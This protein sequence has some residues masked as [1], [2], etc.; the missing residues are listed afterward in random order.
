MHGEARRV[1]KAKETRSGLSS[2]LLLEPKDLFAKR[3][4]LI[5]NAV[6]ARALDS[7][8]NK[9][10]DRLMVAERPTK[11]AKAFGVLWKHID[12]MCVERAT[13]SLQSTPRMTPQLQPHQQQLAH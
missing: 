3:E 12:T 2:F 6:P 13:S 9:L 5:R 11:L 4:S 7:R 1:A 8:A 10:V